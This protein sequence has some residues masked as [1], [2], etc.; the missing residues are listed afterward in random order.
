[1]IGDRCHRFNC[2]VLNGV[3][4]N[5]RLYWKLINTKLVDNS[6]SHWNVS[7]YDQKVIRISCLSYSHNVSWFITIYSNFILDVSISLNSRIILNTLMLP[8]V[9]ITHSLFAEWLLIFFYSLHPTDWFYSQSRTYTPT[10]IIQNIKSIKISLKY[11]TSF[12]IYQ[13]KI[14][15]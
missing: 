2:N 10:L 6:T 7:D 4:T 11:M 5:Q 15:S 12:I 14:E 9:F 8:F 13:N 3:F 1:M